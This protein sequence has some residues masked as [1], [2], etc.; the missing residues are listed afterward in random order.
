MAVTKYDATWLRGAEV[1]QACAQFGLDEQ[2]A[3]AWLSR[4]IVDQGIVARRQADP[5]KD[6]FRLPHI[7]EWHAG[8]RWR[9]AIDTMDWTTFSIG[10]PH[11]RRHLFDQ[12]PIEV[13]HDLLTAAFTNS[14]ASTTR[15]K[16]FTKRTAREFVR[17]YIAQEI[18]ANREPTKLGTR[19]AAQRAGFRGVRKMVDPE[20]DMQMTAR[21]VEVARGRRSKQTAKQ[22]AKK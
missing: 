4:A 17:N 22:T 16:R 20:Y 5:D 14:I 6:L 10:A 8:A 9:P 7:V 3:I 15:A 18:A 1:F 21:G 12:F 11:A 19:D 13:S 2:A